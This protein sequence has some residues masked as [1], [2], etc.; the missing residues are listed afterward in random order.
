M[1]RLLLLPFAP[2]PGDPDGNAARIAAALRQAAGADLLV[3]P[4]AALTGA[5]LGDLGRQPD[6]LAGCEACLRRL[7][8]L[9]AGGGPGLLLGA[10]WPERGPDGGAA[11]EG[12]VL[13]DGGRI[14][15]RRATHAPPGATPDPPVP[16]PGLAPGPAPGPMAFRGLRLGV[17]TGADAEDPAVAET[18]AE[19]GAELLLHLRARP[20]DGAPPD[21]AIDRAVARVVETGLPWLSLG[22]LGSAEGLVFP[23]GAFAL[24]ADRRLAARLPDFT[25]EALPVTLEAEAG[26]WQ[27]GMAPLPPEETAM[28]RLWRALYCG[29]RAEIRAGGHDGITVATE[30][31]AAPLLAALAAA[32]A[33]R[34]PGPRHPGPRRPLRLHGLDKT[35]MALELRAVGGSGAGAGEGFAPL[36]DLWRGEWAALARARGLPAP[37]A[38]AALEAVLEALL[39][40]EKG[41]DAI[42]A[43]GYDPAG[44]RSLWRRMLAAEAARRRAPPGLRLSGR[45]F[46]HDRRYP[47]ALPGPDEPD[48]WA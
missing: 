17:L 35:A 39:R 20:F 14:L 22:L 11:R 46:G 12:A 1:Q 13:I 4:R 10:L 32:C 42:A 26:G 16:A 24:N 37:P 15:A 36:R 18:L 7:A 5:P 19:T 8:A 6:F 41:V 43:G 30:G 29:L 9:T 28:D 27:A 23:G 44:V 33:P 2:R 21:G 3:L 25:P 47:P 45:A 34:H 48:E 40:G 38:D 31:E